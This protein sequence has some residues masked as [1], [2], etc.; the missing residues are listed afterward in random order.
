M[1]G[2]E[3]QR[4]SYDLTEL[5]IRLKE[6]EVQVKMTC[7]VKTRYND[8]Q[9]KKRLSAVGVGGCGKF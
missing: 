9:R 3:T 8:S 1:R 6:E 7:Y 4:T 2:K 5:N